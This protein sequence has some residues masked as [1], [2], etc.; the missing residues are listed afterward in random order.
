MNL[1]KKNPQTKCC[2]MPGFYW[3]CHFSKWNF[4]LSWVSRVWQICSLIISTANR[5]WACTYWRQWKS[6]LWFLQV[7]DQDLISFTYTENNNNYI[8]TRKGNSFF[9][10]SKWYTSYRS[11][12]SSSLYI[13]KFSVGLNFVYFNFY[14]S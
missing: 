11:G 8:L 1:G 13:Q 10:L 6:C 2:K 9:E 14:W 12:S 3:E 5:I 4:I 7:L